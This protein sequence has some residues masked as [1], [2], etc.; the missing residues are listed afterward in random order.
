[1]FKRITAILLV[2]LLS[3]GHSSFAMTGLTPHQLDT[4]KPS[5]KSLNLQT[6]DFVEMEPEEEVRVIIEL[7]GDAPIETATKKGVKYEKLAKSERKGLEIAAKNKQK[8]AK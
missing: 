8:N 2:L 3:I 7:D 5:I 4:Q 6:S 1:M